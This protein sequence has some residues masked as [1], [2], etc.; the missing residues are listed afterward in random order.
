M[1]EF[2]KEYFQTETNRH[3][4]P[5]T[6]DL[7]KAEV[8]G[9]KE[10]EAYMYKIPN[11]RY[12]SNAGNIDFSL[13]PNGVWSDYTGIKIVERLPF[14][15]PSIN[16]NKLG[17]ITP[18]NLNKLKE[19]IK[20]HI[21]DLETAITESVNFIDSGVPGQNNLPYLPEGCVW[22]R[23][24][25]IKDV[26]ALPISDLYGKFNQMV[27]TLK[28]EFEK[29]LIAGADE[30]LIEIIKKFKE[31]TDKQ[32]GILAGAGSAFKPKQVA[33]IEILKNVNAKVDEVYEVLGYYRFDDGANHKRKI[34]REDDGS[35][36][37]LNN[38]LYAN[39]YHQIS[40]TFVVHPRVWGIVSEERRTTGFVETDYQK[41]KTNAEGIRKAI[42]FANKIK[43]NKVIFEKCEFPICYYEKSFFTMFEL[44]SDTEYDFNGSVIWIMF[45]SD[46]ASPFMPKGE[47]PIT[48]WK[49]YVFRP[50]NPARNIIVKN[51]ELIGDRYCRSYKVLGWSGDNGQEQTYGFMID[52]GARNVRLEN[53]IVHGF[54][55]DSLMC[56]LRGGTDSG[57]IWN[58]TFTLG[59]L[60]DVG[61]EEE[62][63]AKYRTDYL[64]LTD[65]MIECRTITTIT[66]V[67]YSMI[68]DSPYSKYTLYWFDE[69]KAFISKEE[70]EYLDTTQ[71]P[72]TA[73]YIK[74]L[75]NFDDK[76]QSE[77]TKKFKFQFVPYQTEYLTVYNCE[78][79]NNNRGGISNL[80]SNSLIDNCYIHD[81]GAG[82]KNGWKNFPDTTRYAINCEDAVGKNI[83]IRNCVI[84]SEFNGILIQSYTCKIQGN[85]LD[86]NVGAVVLY[87][88]N[89]SAIISNNEIKKGYLN[90]V[91]KE[92]KRTDTV[93]VSNNICTNVKI[94][95][96]NRACLY[97]NVFYSTEFNS[98]IEISDK[99]NIIGENTFIY[100]S[101]LQYK[102]V[103]L[104]SNCITKYETDEDLGYIVLRYSDNIYLDETVGT[105]MWKYRKFLSPA[106]LNKTKYNNIAIVGDWE[107]DVNNNKQDSLLEFYN[108][109][110]KNLNFF[111][112]DK[113]TSSCVNK[114]INFANSNIGGLSLNCRHATEEAIT[115]NFNFINCNFDLTTKNITHSY[116]NSIKEGNISINFVNCKFYNT[117]S[118]KDTIGTKVLENYCTFI[119]CDFAN[120]NPPSTVKV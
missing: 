79:F 93:V 117:G 71:I 22:F 24:P 28:K 67:D 54:M 7:S 95:D 2:K 100:K 12:A 103:P 76:I 43:A 106:K 50:H 99:N 51:L 19:E 25:V 30:A 101:P 83:V 20:K 44:Y 112:L 35:G 59:G 119:G 109:N 26:I 82:E 47:N 120:L 31:E 68:I 55:G 113:K 8:Y 86:V 72:K 62:S 34:A 39:L 5:T 107:I 6:L 37:L 78:F 14:F 3:L 17:D 56:A 81:N 49:G 70:V 61:V 18:S 114:T 64:T 69:N 45:D 16:F 116:F 65:E 60:S 48:Y 73:K 53:L 66:E 88:S 105:I 11:D 118:L 74:A 92:G 13:Y 77:P 91:M 32:L 108:L 10:R 33:N 21:V 46:N 80:C 57:R 58:P 104:F 4:Y 102:E 89:H 111:D 29:V 23:D 40:S 115:Y 85:I 87:K 63:N 97:N 27:E 90:S 94:K 84:Q 96:L 75:L 41:A 98:T 110:C 42:K 15:Q 1:L 52:R 36:V 9:C 38:G